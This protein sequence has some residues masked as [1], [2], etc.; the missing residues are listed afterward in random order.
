MAF[1]FRYNSPTRLAYYTCQESHGPERENLSGGWSCGRWS[2]MGGVSP[3]PTLGI[4]NHCK[5]P[6]CVK[7]CPPVP[8]S[9]RPDGRGIRPP[10]RRAVHRLRGLRV[11]LPLRGGVLQRKAGRDTELR[12]MHGGAGGRSE[13]AV[14]IG[15]LG[16]PADTAAL[17]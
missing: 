1:G 11:E 8:C 12:R 10:R 14:R 7:A 15:S 4:C 16:N 2:K 13:T 5:K 6:Y 9:R 3:F 17:S